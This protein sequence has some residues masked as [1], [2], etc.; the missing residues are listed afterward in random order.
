MSALDQVLARH[1]LPTWR[2]V[3]WTIVIA[4]VA[5]VIWAGFAR[6]EEVSVAAG[7]VVPQGRVKVVQHLEGGIIEAILVRE[8][9]VVRAGQALITLDLGT[10]ALNEDELQARLDGVLLRRARLAAEV[11]FPPVPELAQEATGPDLP[12]DA[13]QRQPEVASA[14]AAAFQARQ[15]ELASALKVIDAR[16]EQRTLQV[17]ELE[18]R[19]LAVA[20][21]LELARQRL[22]M[23]AALLAR[24]LTA[25]MDHVQIQAEVE[26]LEGELAVLEP[27]IPRARAAVTEAEQQ[28][29]E[30]VGRFVREAQEQLGEAENTVARLR[31][32]LDA[33]T[34]QELRAEIRSPID[35]IVK[36]MRYNTIGGVVA[37]GE[38]IMEIVPSADRLVVEARLSPT[39]RGY[40]AVGQRAVVKVT[41]Y[42]FIRYGGLDGTVSHVAPD[43]STTEKGVPFFRVV[44]ET[45]RASLGPDGT[46]PITPGMQATVDIHTGE[47]SVL[48]YLLK[49]ILKLRDEAFRER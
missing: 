4:V 7:E 28:S 27:A 1:P 11:A 19:Q 36:N 21:N 14:E 24:K 6:L 15:R 35:G 3:A 20:R 13:A 39:D 34:Q 48:F 5:L 41:A 43:S 25:R 16:I 12:N 47:R 37:P 30:A 40:V 17:E 33:A 22:G 45:D 10:T 42:E 49:P 32:L 8:G 44:V 23:S 38:S 46:L 18:A 31:E 26:S 2:P 9:D 29:A